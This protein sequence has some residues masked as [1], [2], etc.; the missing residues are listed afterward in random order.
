[1]V[2]AVVVVVAIVVVVFV[3]VVVVVVVALDAD[4][5]MAHLLFFQLGKK[6]K[7][8]LI[9]F[10]YLMDSTRGGCVQRNSVAIWW[11]HQKK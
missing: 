1:M 6:E 9:Y 7:E 4:R 8:T 5:P 11:T 2:V 10:L 3:V